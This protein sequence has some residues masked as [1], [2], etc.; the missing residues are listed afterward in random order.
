MPN[1]TNKTFRLPWLA[2]ASFVILTV[3]PSGRTESIQE[4]F[5]AM[6]EN[7]DGISSLH[8]ESHVTK[9]L[10]APYLAVAPGANISVPT[11]FDFRYW[12]KGDSFNYEVENTTP[13]KEGLLVRHARA[14]DYDQYF[15]RKAGGKL[16][17]TRRPSSKEWLTTDNGLFLPYGFLFQEEEGS[18]SDFIPRMPSLAD[19]NSSEIWSKVASARDVKILPDTADPDSVVLTMTVPGGE[20]EKAFQSTE[21]SYEVHLSKKRK[22]FPITIKKRNKS[23]TL[24]HEVT[25]SE[26]GEIKG[27]SGR[28]T[29]FPRVATYRSYNGKGDLMITCTYNIDKLEVDA[30]TGEEGE[31]LF[32]IDPATAARIYDKDNNV[33]ISVPR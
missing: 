21:Y 2:V 28:I 5:S 8:A 33:H 4:I 7:F 26:I 11:T 29:Y 9:K 30:I 10:E 3:V 14:Q 19:L 24:I 22:F 13:G 16:V 32:N 15:S 31:D 18:I 25:A 27:S 1:R 6:K 23:G 12:E 17:V 20:M